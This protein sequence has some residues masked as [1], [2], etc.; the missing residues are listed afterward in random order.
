MRKSS[1][2]GL[3]LTSVLLFSAVHGDSITT[4]SKHVFAGETFKVSFTANP[5]T[6]AHLAN[7]SFEGQEKSVFVPALESGEFREELEFQAPKT[8]GTY[9]MTVNSLTRNQVK[10]EKPL[11]LIEEM[12]LKPSSIKE[13]E[14]SLVRFR[15]S[16]PGE[17]TV[18]NVGYS[19]RV[20]GNPEML[21]FQKTRQG[22]GKI[23]RPGSVFE[24]NA[25]IS[26]R[27]NAEGSFIVELVV[28]YEF[29]GETHKTVKD[30][31]LE[32][33]RHSMDWLANAVIVLLILLVLV[34]ILTKR[35]DTE[36]AKV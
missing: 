32:I 30:E 17:Y 1:F 6:R 4:L 29:N 12:T 10:V 26:A 3:A 36:G 15:F 9:V 21:D 34:L 13:G 19:L 2:L 20:R 31:T 8:P 24:N 14:S 7:V 18:Y 27:K 33:I 5:P 22:V 25:S 16:N 28:D 23:F 35:F 11:V